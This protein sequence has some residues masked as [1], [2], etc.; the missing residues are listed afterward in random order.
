MDSQGHLCHLAAG[1][2]APS[3]PVCSMF[4]WFLKKRTTYHNTSTST[5]FVHIVL[6]GF[7]IFFQAKLP[8]DQ[9][10]ERDMLQGLEMQKKQKEKAVARWLTMGMADGV[11]VV[12]GDKLWDFGGDVLI[13][14][15]R[16]Y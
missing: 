1:S 11:T 14:D 2:S 6:F 9:W 4:S 13:D 7:P 16:W 10:Q 3:S 15:Y 8:I 5:S 12:G